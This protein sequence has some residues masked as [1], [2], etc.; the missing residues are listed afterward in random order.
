LP[1]DKA[2]EA[3]VTIAQRTGDAARDLPEPVIDEVRRAIAAH[4]EVERLS[5][6]LDGEEDLDPGARDRMF[7]EQLPSG[8]VAADL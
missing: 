1:A 3:L 8:L 5:A 6:V 4:P 2:A 7:G